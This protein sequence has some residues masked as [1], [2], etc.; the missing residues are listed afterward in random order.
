[1][2]PRLRLVQLSN[3]Y[4]RRIDAKLSCVKPRSQNIGLHHFYK[5]V[6]LLDRR[7]RDW[8]LEEQMQRRFLLDIDGSSQSTRLYW[9]LLS[10]SLVFKQAT[11]CCNWYSDRL[12]DY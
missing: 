1:M 2:F 12:K 8:S 11:R 6:G 7:L 10:N 4:P 5:R 9:A 3:N